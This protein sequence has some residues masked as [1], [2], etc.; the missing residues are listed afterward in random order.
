MAKRWPNQENED[1]IAEF[2]TDF[3]QL[4]LKY[5]LQKVIQGIYTLR[6]DPNQKFFPKPD[7]VAEEIENQERKIKAEAERAQTQELLARYN[8]DFWKWV[9]RRMAD[10]DMTGK[11]EQNLLDSIR[12][13]GYIGLRARQEA[14]SSAQ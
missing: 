5:S 14:A 6:I 7:E 11:T 4:A 2:L 3:E 12:V 9:D 13:P 8:T 10:L 1:T